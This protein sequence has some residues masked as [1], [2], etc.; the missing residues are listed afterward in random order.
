MDCEKPNIGIKA[1]A[2]TTVNFFMIVVFNS[3]PLIFGKNDL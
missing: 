1:I 2:I 3:L